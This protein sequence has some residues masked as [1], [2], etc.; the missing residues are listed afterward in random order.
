MS[1]LEN[2][3][4]QMNYALNNAMK[5]LDKAIMR[6]PDDKLDFKPID[7]VMGIGELGIHVYMCSLVYTAG[8]LKGEFTD[9]DYSTIPFDYKNVKSAAEIVEYGKK[10]KAYIQET[11]EKLTEADMQKDVTY[12]CWGGVKISGFASM[13]TILEEVIHHRG[14]LCVYLRLLGIEPPF[15]YDFS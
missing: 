15:I 6:I 1:Q 7:T 10:I 9:D 13:A 4:Q 3:K 5:T 14:Q 2:I 11:L 12:T 8:T